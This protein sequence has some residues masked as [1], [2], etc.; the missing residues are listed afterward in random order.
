MWLLVGGSRVAQRAGARLSSVGSTFLDQIIAG[1]TDDDVS[2]TSLLR[3]VKVVG[4]R[5]QA[6]EVERWAE[7]EL[8]GFDP[9]QPELLPSHRGP[10]EV[11]VKGRYAWPGD[12]H[13]THPLHPINVPD[14][15]A[16][17]MFKLSMFQPI[18]ELEEAA[19]GDH[20]L[21]MPWP[22]QAV[23][24]WKRWEADGTVAKPTFMMLYNADKVV[25]RLMVRGVVS[26]I[27]D[28]ALDF[29]LRLQAVDTKAGEVDGPTVAE[30]EVRTVVNN[31]Y[32]DG[33]LVAVGD[34]NT[35]SATVAK[36]DLVGLLSAARN[37]GLGDK[38]L[39][40]LAAALTGD[41]APESKRSRL[42]VYLAK[43][44]AGTYVLAAGVTADLAATGVLELA[45]QF[46]G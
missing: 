46:L 7:S 33:N 21:V 43:L 17:A 39:N 41:D 29:A 20:D 40:A 42:D 10:L 31:F 8:A 13:A 34:G 18:A 36:G 38:A 5:L 3:K 23:T 44:R 26:Q 15:F 2:T 19:N 16:E 32:G 45:Q 35:L 6:V 11:P 4:H 14:D 37:L 25:S 24:Q 27:R 28:K 12:S 22:S 30:A 1:A 9:A